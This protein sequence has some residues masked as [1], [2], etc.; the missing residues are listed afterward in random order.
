MRDNTYDSADKQ[1]LDAQTHSG[2]QES[3]LRVVRR[4]NRDAAL[5]VCAPVRLCV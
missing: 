1:I 2:E 4:T 3:V 5:C